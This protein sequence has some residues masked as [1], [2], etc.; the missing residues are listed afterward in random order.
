MGAALNFN[1]KGAR[2]AELKPDSGVQ[3]KRL[4]SPEC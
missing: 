1:Y 2:A 4:S 3:R